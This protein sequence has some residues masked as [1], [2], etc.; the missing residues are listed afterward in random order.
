MQQV[1][2]DAVSAIGLQ[3]AFYYGLAGI[4]AVVAY[5]GLLF[6]SVKNLLVGGLWPLL[7]S[8][9]MLWAFVESLG[10]LSTTALAIGLGGLLLG[11]VPLAVYGRRGSDYYRRPARLDAVRA[12]AA[13]AAA[14]ASTQAPARATGTRATRRTSDGSRTRRRPRW[15][16]AAAPRARS[17]PSASCPTS[18]RTSGTGR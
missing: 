7:G 10:E 5:K 13:S 11:V 3:I 4:A 2:S 6:R 14:G 12:L 1:L 18:T 17:A 8:A 16:Y 9:F 15:P